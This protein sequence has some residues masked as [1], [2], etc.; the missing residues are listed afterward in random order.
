MKKQCLLLLATVLILVTAG[1]SSG[2]SQEEY[3]KV[4]SEKSTIEKERTE[5]QN[6]YTDLDNQYNALSSSMDALEN[7]YGEYKEKMKPFEELSEKEAEARKIEAEKVIEQQKKEEEEKRRKEEE[8]KKQEEA[9]GY[10]TGITYDQLARTPDDYVGKKVKF[11]GE[12]IQVIE[13]SGESTIQIRLAVNS[14]YDTILLGEYESDIVSSR[15]LENDIIT[16]YGVSAGTISYESTLG[17]TIT[18]PGVLIERI[19][20]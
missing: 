4:V 16:I 14:D 7:E 17:A 9:K 13:T 12:V 20:Q 6:K 15:I 1:C 5:L 10:E 19:D 3:D 8:K 11:K 18:I 2:I